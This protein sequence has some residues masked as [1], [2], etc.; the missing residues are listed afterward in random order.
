MN[1]YCELLLLFGV[2]IH[3]SIL[4]LAAKNIGGLIEHTSILNSIWVVGL[5]VVGA[6][7]K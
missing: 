5:L 2:I 7:R 4:I 1:K 6:L 3:L